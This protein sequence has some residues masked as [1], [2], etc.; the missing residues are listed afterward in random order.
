MFTVVDAIEGGSLL[1]AAEIG[2]IE[3]IIMMSPKR[4][5]AS[6]STSPQTPCKGILLIIH[7]P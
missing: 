7:K 5:L 4:W 6:R 1:W 3:E 2:E